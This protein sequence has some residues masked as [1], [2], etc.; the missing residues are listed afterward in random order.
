[1]GKLFNVDNAEQVKATILSNLRFPWVFGEVSTLGGRD[2]VTIMIKISKDPQYLWA[3]G[4]L[5]NSTYAMF[6]ID[7]NGVVEQFSGYKLKLRKFT[8][9]NVSQIIEK[10]NNIKIVT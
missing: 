5:H 4:I 6:H 1:M 9:K 2:N 10:I 7:S 3:N 8:A